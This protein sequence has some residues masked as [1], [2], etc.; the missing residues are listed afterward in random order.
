M[1]LVDNICYI[2]TVMSDAHSESVSVDVSL[3]ILCNQ[4]FTIKVYL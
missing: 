1:L 4:W 2:L 3:I